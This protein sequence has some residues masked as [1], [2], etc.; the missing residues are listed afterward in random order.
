MSLFSDLKPLTDF[1]IKHATD[2][3]RALETL[4]KKSF[5]LIHLAYSSYICQNCYIPIIWFFF[6]VLGL[7]SE[8]PLAPLSH[9]SDF[10]KMIRD[11]MAEWLRRKTRNFQKTSYLLGSARAGSNPAGVE[12]LFLAFFH[13]FLQFRATMDIIEY[14]LIFSVFFQ[15]IH[16]LFCLKNV[17]FTFNKYPVHYQFCHRGFKPPRKKL[18]FASSNQVNITTKAQLDSE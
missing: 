5:S 7:F 3:R 14:E 4:P 6:F 17:L 10:F 1:S 12:S 2:Q 13:F 9:S 15:Y 18:T 11:T 16:L 8:N